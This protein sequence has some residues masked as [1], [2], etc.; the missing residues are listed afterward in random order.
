VINLFHPQDIHR[1]DFPAM[2][3]RRVL[4]RPLLLAAAAVGV[5]SKNPGSSEASCTAEEYGRAVK[6]YMLQTSV[7]ASYSEECEDLNVECDS[8]AK[9][10]D[11]LE[12]F[13]WMGEN[14][15]KS[16]WACFDKDRDEAE[17]RFGVEQTTSSPTWTDSVAAKV[18]S[19]ISRTLE[20]MAETVYAEEEFS[21]VRRDCFNSDPKCSYYAA[22][23]ECNSRDIRWMQENCGPACESC[24]AVEYW[25]EC[26][27][28][29]DM[30]DVLKP[31]ELNKMFETIVST[32][33][34]E[35]ITIVSY[36][37][38]REQMVRD[39]NIQFVEQQIVESE[40]EHEKPWI[41]TIDDFLTDAESSFLIGQGEKYGFD[42]SE[43]DLD[44]IADLAMDSSGEIDKERTSSGTFC[45]D[46]CALD[47]VTQRITQRINGLTG[48]PTGNLEHLQLVKYG[49][50]DQYGEHHDTVDFW[51][52]TFCG[53][54]ILTIFLYLNEP[55]RGGET[56]FPVLNLGVK[57]KKG[58]ALL[59]PSVLDS[60][61]N[62][63]D[64]WTWHQAM[65][66]LEGQKYAANAW[67]HLRDFMNFE[68]DYDCL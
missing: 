68:T 52:D 47:P 57:P 33:P 38:R 26:G 23:G 48:I 39:S 63:I 15:P 29:E 41:L 28:L 53:H 50:G 18:S 37:E 1:I 62:L 36:P 24:R 12:N 4:T 35:K 9:E 10:G 44:W 5:N 32:Y 20:Y 46:E 34:K 51:A 61:L 49:I 43:I 66:V 14:C 60:D 13:E 42:R 6:G 67:F 55:E 30:D 19:V 27:S 58:M 22:M 45:D 7:A 16:C 40:L 54:R 31:G 64:E 65:P 3:R 2:K 8:W 56:R 25:N 17:L 11:C 21:N 59:W